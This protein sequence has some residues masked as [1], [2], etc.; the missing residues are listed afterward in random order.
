MT[1][2]VLR[3]PLKEFDSE[4]ASTRRLLERA[5]SERAEWKP[6]PKSVPLAHLA[7]LVR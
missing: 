2:H 5:P 6:H 1:E 7:Q 4:M 3:I